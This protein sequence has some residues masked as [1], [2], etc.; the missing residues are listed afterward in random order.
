MSLCIIYKTFHFQLVNSTLK[1]VPTINAAFEHHQDDRHYITDVSIR[2]A[3]FEQKPNIF[4][5]KSAWQLHSNDLYSTISGS[6][7]MQT[8]LNG[9]SKGSLAT[10]FSLSSAKAL[11]GAADFE[12]ESK[13]FTLAVDGIVK[14]LTN[15]MLVVN[16]TTP[17]EKYRNIVSRFGLVDRK[18]HFV[19]EVRAPGSALGIE[20]KFDIE[21]MS[22]FDVIFNLEAPI[23]FSLNATSESFSKMMLIGKLQPEM[24]DFQGALNK[25]KLGYVGVSRNTSPED[26]EYSWKV[27]TPLDHFEESSLVVKYIRKPVLDMEVML[28]FAQK[29][30]GFFVNGKSKQK[31]I[32]LPKVEHSLP[33]KSKLSDDFDKFT[34]YFVS[35]SMSDTKENADNVEDAS[36]K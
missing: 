6:M 33:F 2:H 25:Y 14:K 26:F 34:K 22:Q 17:I 27:Y 28:K 32:N 36:S 29:K 35:K 11:K 12:L 9:Y 5:I 3:P 16:V 21:S 20:V 18:R 4:A 19:A 15:C 31:L 10:K 1:Q 23:I 30:L 7:M 24:I 8:P 13:K